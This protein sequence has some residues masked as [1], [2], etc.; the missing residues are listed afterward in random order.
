MDLHRVEDL[1]PYLG[2]SYPFVVIQFRRGGEDVVVSRRAL[3]EEDRSDEAKSVRATLLEGA[4][5]RGRVANVADF[6]A[7][8]DLGAGV[9]GLV[10]IS[11]LGHARVQRV[12][13][14]VKVGDAVQVKILK[15]DDPRGRISL[16]IRQ[17]EKD[18]WELLS[19]RFEIGSSYQGRV[20]RV[21]EFGAFVELAPGFEALAPAREFRPSPGGWPY[22]LEPGAEGSWLVTALEPARR[23]ATVVPAPPEGAGLEPVKVEPGLTLAGRV[24]RIERFGVFVWLSHGQVGLLP[25]ALS[26]VQRGSDLDRRFPI[27]KE[28]EVDVVDVED[29]GRKIRLALKG[30]AREAAA[31]P[32]APRRTRQPAGPV[33]GEPLQAAAGEAGTFGNALADALKAALDKPR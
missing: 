1:T 28:I 24:Q 25:T 18:P 8:I 6:G 17:A 2:N 13:D 5:M 23:R 7:F 30:V 22:G 21:A 15:L 11:E 4:V 33:P 29:D 19:Q 10:H 9:T 16:S 32:R 12:S 26:G 3:L 27:G 31:P 20:N 14:A